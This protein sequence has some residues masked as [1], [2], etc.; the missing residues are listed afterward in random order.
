M[1][2]L[3]GLGSL[4][5][6]EDGSEAPPPK[7]SQFTYL[8][9]KEIGG[10]PGPVALAHINSEL[11]EDP[12]ASGALL[13]AMTVLGV[14]KVYCRYD[15]GNDEGFAWFDHAQTATGQRITLDDLVPTLKSGPAKKYFDQRSSWQADMSDA[16]LVEDA[17]AF[18]LTNKW[19]AALL[20]GRGFG[21]G[22]YL[23]YGAFV[24][25]LV[26]GTMTDDPAASVA[27]RHIEIE[28]IERSREP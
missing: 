25:D 3:V 26:A 5:W 11:D 4:P 21:T 20:G 12:E 10:S 23:M 18:P 15:G 9:A 19:A 1:P 2:F 27:V 8:P 16:V 28:G 7:A 6:P 14:V 24:V 13:E 17:L 22:E